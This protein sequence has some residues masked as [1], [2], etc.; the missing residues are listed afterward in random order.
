MDLFVEAAQMMASLFNED[1]TKATYRFTMLDLVNK[2]NGVSNALRGIATFVTKVTS[3][4]GIAKVVG[5]C[6]AIFSRLAIAGGIFFA[7]ARNKDAW[8]V[9]YGAFNAFNTAATA[10]RS[11]F[12]ASSCN[13]YC[14]AR[15]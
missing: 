14:R 12:Q 8:S 15:C 6:A 10:A 11:R 4:N 9:G 5:G 2:Q 7:P 3:G 13:Q 1:S